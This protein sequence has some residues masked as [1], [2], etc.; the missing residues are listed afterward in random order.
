MVRKNF[1]IMKKQAA[2]RPGPP[3]EAPVLGSERQSAHGV[4]QGK[5]TQS[6]QD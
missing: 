5:K 2:S 1:L 4:T 3:Q 6:Q